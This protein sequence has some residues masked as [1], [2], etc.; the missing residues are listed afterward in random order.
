MKNFLEKNALMGKV[1]RFVIFVILPKEYDRYDRY[2]SM[3]NMTFSYNDVFD[4]DTQQN[5][6]KWGL[7]ILPREKRIFMD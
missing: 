4:S 3:T 2:D 7:F 1:V 6:I 5:R